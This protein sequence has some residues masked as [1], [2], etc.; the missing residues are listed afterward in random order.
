M[1]P[2]PPP[3]DT[4]L[5]PAPDE[6]QPQDELCRRRNGF[7]LH[8]ERQLQAHDRKGLEKLL[9]YGA[10]APIAASRLSIDEE[11]RVV[12]EL[13]KP[14]GVTGTTV[15]RLSPSDFLRRL[16]ML[17]PPPYQNL[18]RHY[19]VFASRSK[20]RPLLPPPPARPLEPP[21]PAASQDAIDDDRDGQDDDDLEQD[22]DT[23]LPPHERTYRLPWAQ[24]MKR[25][26]G[27]DPLDCKRCATPMVILAFISNFD[28]VRRILDHLK[29]PTDVV[30]APLAHGPWHSQTVLDVLEP[31]PEVDSTADA[32]ACCAQLENYFG[33]AR[34]PPSR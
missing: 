33:K 25:L 11:G 10:R 17:I 6:P 9:R 3:S 13:T 1:L 28:V 31:R 27:L 24:L 34:G 32:S 2:S 8:A 22:Q 7:S 20:L 29:T 30:P 19:G 23:V 26:L 21:T 18:I 16:A 15:L 12:Y 5:A 4:H 14:W